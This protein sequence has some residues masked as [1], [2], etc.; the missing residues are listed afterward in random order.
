MWSYLQP[1]FYSE[2]II[3]EMQ[4]EGSKYSFV[5]RLW[6]GIMNS[7][8]NMPNVMDACFQ[9]RLKENFALM[10]EQLEQV[11]KGLNEYLNRKRT[12]FPRFYFLSNDEMLNILSQAREPSSVQKHL[13]KIFEGIDS[14]TF[15]ESLLITH[16]NSSEGEH[17]EF[18]KTISPLDS[19]KQPRGVEEWLNE[20][21]T[22]MK[23]T[24]LNIFAE[25]LKDLASGQTKRK[26]WLFKWPAQVVIVCE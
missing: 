21:E 7:A 12:A 4:K 8:Y 6:R 18:A 11:I 2:E 24:L 19:Q 17:I 15:E 5:D 10:I 16:M 22:Q 23:A 13:A 20:I 14:L 1:I 9:S 25:S 3:K 26:D